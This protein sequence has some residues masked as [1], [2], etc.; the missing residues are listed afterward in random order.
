MIFFLFLSIC[1]KISIFTTGIY[2]FISKKLQIIILC[3]QLFHK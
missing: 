3:T 1:I 2:F